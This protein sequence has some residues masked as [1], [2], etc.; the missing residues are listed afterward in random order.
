MNLKTYVLV[1]LAAVFA[2]S[3]NAQPSCGIQECGDMFS[4]GTLK[5]SACCSKQAMD[6]STCCP[7]SC[8]FGSSCN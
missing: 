2:T 8:T 6:F 3:I 1:V 4:D 7:T 5:I